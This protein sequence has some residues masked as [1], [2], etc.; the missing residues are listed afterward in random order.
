[1]AVKTLNICKNGKTVVDQVLRYKL[2]Q[3][4][5]SNGQLLEDAF[6][7]IKEYYDEFKLVW[8]NQVSKYIDYPTFV[9]DFEFKLIRAVDTFDIVRAESLASKNKWSLKGMF[10]RWFFSIIKNWVR[11][12]HTQGFGSKKRPH[13]QCPVCGKFVPKIDEEHLLHLRTTSELP[14]VIRYN[15]KIYNTYIKP[16]KS[17]VCWGDFSKQKMID[18]C[19]G[20]RNGYT[21][22]SIKWIWKTE[23][24]LPG[25]LCPLTNKIVKEINN[26]YISD[27]PKNLKHY[28]EPV[29][30]S[31]F[32]T[33]YPNTI[34]YVDPCSL[35]QE[36]EDHNV[37]FYE[38]LIAPES[39][40]SVDVSELKNFSI[41]PNVKYQDTFALIDS[42]IG[43]KVENNI[44][45]LL[46]MGVPIDEIGNKIKESTKVVKSK[47]KH[48]QEKFSELKNGLVDLIEK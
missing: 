48:I 12:V 6:L 32:N 47:I 22:N 8:F 43:D 14:S 37:S 36:K 38:Q 5:G 1:M 45:K 16:K 35:D 29:E 7:P 2:L 10:N 23:D 26:Q 17:T 15:N 28:A 27:L 25:V 11:N 9:S 4:L 41:P 31:T 24:G 34:L 39:G 42:H 18:L 20:K 33:N 46:C 13:V 3:D 40:S 19:E 30:W 44:C 21:K